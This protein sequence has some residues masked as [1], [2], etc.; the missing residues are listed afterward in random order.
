MFIAASEA[1]VTS[2]ISRV[3]QRNLGR[4]L[5]ITSAVIP[6]GLEEGRPVTRLINNRRAT[7]YHYIEPTFRKNLYIDASFRIEFIPKQ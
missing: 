3:R 7:L 5:S 4:L 1:K 2:S 6:N